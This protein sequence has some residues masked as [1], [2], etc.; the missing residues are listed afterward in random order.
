MQ[1]C[2]D[3]QTKTKTKAER[4]GLRAA[5]RGEHSARE[6]QSVQLARQGQVRRGH[7]D[8]VGECRC[9]ELVLTKIFV[10]S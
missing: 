9:D 7:S 5:E 10:V 8:Q 3:L 1:T 4:D 2:L 6:Q